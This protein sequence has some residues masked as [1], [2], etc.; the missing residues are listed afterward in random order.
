MI[1]E[2]CNDLFCWVREQVEYYESVLV[3]DEDY[4]PWIKERLDKQG[5]NMEFTDNRISITKCNRLNK[6]IIYNY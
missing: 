1:C 5:V 2:N 3:T 4:L 6:Y